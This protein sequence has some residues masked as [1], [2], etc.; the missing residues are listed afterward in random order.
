M[1]DIIQKISLIGIIPVIA[2]DDAADAVPL[3]KALID[4]GLPAAE[5]TFRT[6]A[7]ADAIAAMTAADPEL[8]VGA[9][10]VLNIEQCQ[11]ALKAGAKFI[12]SPGYN[13]ELV[14]YCI[15]MD[16]PVLPG[17][18]N[19]SEMT[20][21]VN[22]GLSIVKFFPAETSG[23]LDFLK[24]LAPVFPS[25]SFMPT[26]GVNTGNLSAYMSYPRIFACGGTWMVKKDLISG[27][28]W[29]TIIKICREAVDNMLSLKLA[30]VGI[31]CESREQAVS[32]AEAFCSLMGL[33]LRPGNSSV[34][35]GTQVECLNAPGLGSNGHIAFST[36]NVDRAVYHLK[37]RGVEFRMETRKADANGKTKAIY[38]KNEIG[39]FAIHLVQK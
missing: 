20:K 38:L 25:L 23:G 19:A 10:T 32:D 2:I 26:G 34:F 31:N 4:G 21:A 5:V 17:C 15:S 29:D 8:L 16:I 14:N 18:V 11:R 30:H 36:P 3:A 24:S 37:Q 13:S 28:Q 9:G 22:A 39:G 7:A 35:S 1:N 6:A 12:V 33:A 27:H